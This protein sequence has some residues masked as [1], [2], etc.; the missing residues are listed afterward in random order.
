MDHDVADAGDGAHLD[1]LLAG[2][3]PLGRTPGVPYIADA[4]AHVE[5]GGRG[6]P[7][8]GLQFPGGGPQVDAS[9]GHFTDADAAVD[10]LG[11]HVGVGRADRY[12]AV[13]RV[14]PHRSAHLLEH[15]VPVAVPDDGP[16]VHNSCVDPAGTVNSASPAT[17]SRLMSP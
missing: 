7:D 4:G 2:V 1:G 11:V 16:S 12:P 14:H 5:P 8:A 13:G 17:C 3:R 9:A 6:L 15:R 10:G